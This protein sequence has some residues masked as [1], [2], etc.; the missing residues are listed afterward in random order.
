MTTIK[1][2]NGTPEEYWPARKQ[3]CK[4]H[5]VSMIHAGCYMNNYYHDFLCKD[6]NG[7][8]RCESIKTAMTEASE[9]IAKEN[10]V[11]AAE[12]S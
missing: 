6:C 5:G 3:M 7:A 1:N 8:V 9:D 11:E 4:E 12:D 10:V 2:F